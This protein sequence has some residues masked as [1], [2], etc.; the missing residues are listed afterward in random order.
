VDSAIEAL[1]FETK[2]PTKDI[3]GAARKVVAPDWL[4]PPV[5]VAARL[6]RGFRI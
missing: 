5:P 4:P 2:P 1:D 3:F 6:L